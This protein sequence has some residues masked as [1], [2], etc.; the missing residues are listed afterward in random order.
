MAGIKLLLTTV[1]KPYGVDTGDAEALGM[2]ME[3]LNNQ[4]TRDQH[5]HSPR[6]N[7]WT[8]PLYFLAENISVPATVLDFPSWDEFKRELQRGYT[9]VGI[10][11]IQTNV[12][13]AQRM[14]EC[15][16]ADCP[17]T[18]ILL[19]GYGASLPDL[20]SLVPH[21]AV[22]PGE[23]IQW[24]RAYLGEDSQAPIRHPVM[25]GVISKHVYG[26]RGES[27]DS[28]VIFPGLGCKN[29]CFFCATSAKFEGQYIP[30]LPTG[31]SVFELCR[32]AEEELGVREFAVIDENFLKEQDRARDLLGEMERHGKAYQF[33]IF[34][35]AEALL[36]VGVD[37]LVRLGV[38]AVWM[39]LETRAEIFGKLKNIDVSGLIREMQSKGISVISSSILFMEH[40]DRQRL[41]EDIEWAVGMDTD[42]HQFMQLTPLPGTPLFTR[43]QV[44]GKLIPEFP[45]TR[46]SGQNV[47][48]FYHPHFRSEEARDLTRGAF[49][50]K[51]EVG[52]PGVVNMARTALDGYQRAL[53]DAESRKGQGLSWNPA[54]LKYDLTN[55]PGEDCHMQARI[56]LL[57][58]RAGEFRPLLWS[59]WLFSPNRG[60]RQKCLSLMQRYRQVFGRASGSDTFAAGLLCVTA[61][62]EYLRHL[63]ARILRR[64]ELIRQPPSRR[65]EYVGPAGERRPVIY[66]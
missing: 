42:L 50:R 1:C 26:F 17:A 13:K 47:L 60:A 27:N 10:S 18:K 51:Y 62:I 6:A 49:R 58:Q 55:G 8:F 52:G 7:F 33:W 31:R 9:H 34:A 20:A 37:F 56:E 66:E 30:F 14:A 5:V 54:T 25:R 39:G 4:I 3:L 44:E 24:L 22:C 48:A 32:K 36:E 57:R 16:R 12:I 35:S 38:C 41:Q 15:I 59:A 19:G 65:L 43:Y 23:G 46:L 61:A 40:H 21:D 11:F 29:G 64:K 2:Q 45:Y 53:Q 63:W 28:A